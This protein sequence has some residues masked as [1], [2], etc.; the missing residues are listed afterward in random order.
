MNNSTFLWQVERQCTRHY[1]SA[2]RSTNGA[3]G[4]PGR[5]KTSRLGG[6]D[7]NSESFGFGC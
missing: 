1:D 5:K 4:A 3:N 6:R 7:A 2:A